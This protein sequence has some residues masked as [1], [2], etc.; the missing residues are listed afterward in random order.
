MARSQPFDAIPQITRYL[1]PSA[2]GLMHDFDTADCLVG[3]AAA[4]DLLEGLS[5]AGLVVL[6]STVANFVSRRFDEMTSPEPEP[7]TVAGPIGMTS[8][9]YTESVRIR[10][11]KQD[12]SVVRT[13]PMPRPLAEIVLCDHAY[14]HDA[15]IVSAIIEV[16]P[17]WI[18]SLMADLGQSYSGWAA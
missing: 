14:T 13:E 18:E 1:H 6:P 2:C 11:K 9:L 3:I 4:T 7:S 15:D 10:S 16:E 17:S 5:R 12:G 8:F